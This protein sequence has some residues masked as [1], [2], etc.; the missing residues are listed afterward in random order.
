MAS[1]ASHTPSAG[2]VSFSRKKFNKFSLESTS[3]RSRAGAPSFTRMSV[4]ATIIHALKMAEDK[5]VVAFTV[6]RPIFPRASSVNSALTLAAARALL[7]TLVSKQGLPFLKVSQNGQLIE[8][9]L[10]V[11]ASGLFLSYSPTQRGVLSATVFLGHVHEARPASD[12]FSL[13]HTDLGGPETE[14]QCISLVMRHCAPWNVL[15]N[16]TGTMAAWQYTFRFLSRRALE[17]QRRHGA[18]VFLMRLWLDVAFGDH[19]QLRKGKGDHPDD[20][21]DRRDEAGA[22]VADGGAAKAVSRGELLS[23]P[24]EYVTETGDK[25]MFRKPGAVAVSGK[26]H[27]VSNSTDGPSQVP[28]GSLATASSP[29]E[30]RSRERDDATPNAPGEA[31]D[32]DAT[33]E[34]HPDAAAS[35]APAATTARAAISSGNTNYAQ[36][37]LT[38]THVSIRNVADALAEAGACRTET[39]LT[40]QAILPAV[41]TWFGSAAPGGD[42][43]VGRSLADDPPVA[44]PSFAA[45]VSGSLLSP[46]AFN[47]SSPSFTATA[48]PARSL[49]A[50]QNS[51]AYNTRISFAAFNELVGHCAWSG[52]CETIRPLFLRYASVQHEVFHML[53]SS[54]DNSLLWAAPGGGGG[55]GAFDVDAPCEVVAT[56]LIVRRGEGDVTN[57]SAFLP[58]TPSNALPPAALEAA[59]LSADGVGDPAETS[60]AMRVVTV[61]DWLRF[62]LEEQFE[63][64]P[65]LD[66]QKPSRQVASSSSTAG[67]VQDT[68]SAFFAQ[69]SNW[70]S[71]VTGGRR[72]CDCPTDVQTAAQLVAQMK[73]FV[74]PQIALEDIT[75]AQIWPVKGQICGGGGPLHR[76]HQPVD[77]SATANTAALDGCMRGGAGTASPGPSNNKAAASATG[78]SSASIAAFVSAFDNPLMSLASVNAANATSLGTPA[79]YPSQG[80]WAPSILARAV[81]P[82]SATA[83]PTTTTYSPAGSSR[84]LTAVAASIMGPPSSFSSP[85]PATA[86]PPLEHQP[87]LTLPLFVRALMDPTRNGWFK[88]HHSTTIHEDMKQPL[89]H[90]FVKSSHNTYL[91]GDQL[92]S[93]SSCEMYRYALL[94]GCR[95]LELD[96][97][98]GDDGDPII[99]HGHTRTTK[100][101]F[102]DVIKTIDSF[103]FTTSPF[104]VILSLEVHCSDE[105]QQVMALI[106]QTHFREKML[107]FSDDEFQQAMERHQAHINRSMLLEEKRRL[108]ASAPGGGRGG[109]LGGGHASSRHLMSLAASVE[110]L[111]GED[112]EYFS[113]ASASGVHPLS[114]E[115]LKFKILVKGKRS[116][117]KKAT[118]GEKGGGGWGAATGAAH[119]AGAGG[120]EDDDDSSSSDE[121]EGGGGKKSKKKKEKPTSTLTE[122]ANS[123]PPHRGGVLPPTTRQNEPADASSPHREDSNGGDRGVDPDDDLEGTPP[124]PGAPDAPSPL[125]LTPQPPQQPQPSSEVLQTAQQLAQLLRGFARGRQ[126]RDV[127]AVAAK[128]CKDLGTLW[129]GANPIHCCSLGERRIQRMTTNYLTIQQLLFVTRHMFIRVYPAGSRIAS[130]N[131]DPLWSWAHGAQLVALNYQTM[132][133]PMRLNT[134]MFLANGRSGYV[135]KPLIMRKPTLTPAMPGPAAIAASGKDENAAKHKKDHH[136]SAPDTVAHHPPRPGGLGS[137]QLHSAGQKCRAVSFMPSIS[138]SAMKIFI[139][140]VKVICGIALPQAPSLSRDRAKKNGKLE[141]A[142][143]EKMSVTTES[144]ATSTAGAE[145]GGA[146]DG[147]R[148]DDA[149]VATN[150][151]TFLV[152]RPF[153]QIAVSGMA[154]DNTTDVELMQDGSKGKVK[155]TPSIGESSSG[156]DAA[157]SSSPSAFRHHPPHASEW[158]NASR[159]AARAAIIAQHGFYSQYAT[160]AQYSRNRLQ[161]EAELQLRQMQRSGAGGVAGGGGGT[162]RAPP[163]VAP[164]PDDLPTPPDVPPSH[165]NRAFVTR[166]ANGSF[167]PVWL[168]EGSFLI[169]HLE[170]AVLTVRVY[171]HTGA[172]NSG[173]SQLVGESIIRLPSLRLGYR[174]VPL[175]TLNGQLLDDSAILCHFSLFEVNAVGGGGVPA[176]GAP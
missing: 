172:S 55:R 117:P 6:D 24:G 92:Q 161:Y 49:L 54:T 135:L 35:A 170:M 82:S 67:N 107:L 53:P 108:A 73:P 131:Y 19:R 106:M 66:N 148:G 56:P 90:Y 176:A 51:E 126:L 59:K 28:A 153:V 4:N 30:A 13:R 162:G 96:C 100:I 89:S 25:F 14:G 27:A 10:H 52:L 15:F 34:N 168:D 109:L 114:P 167:S 97:W 1:I 81:G 37:T 68:S 42:S 98:D 9:T 95:C 103:A 143:R 76:N 60:K 164:R 140:R 174:A 150:Q 33:P 3:T 171:D 142:E 69:V 22:T 158:A 173:A 105:Q 8:K 12:A 129:E 156:T 57:F 5:E 46:N 154:T 18:R 17:V 50:L 26:S 93:E 110:N 23:Q 38:H 87:V 151:A 39:L 160:L 78:V 64:V 127:I 118:V 169:S 20:D 43:G 133:Y 40:L 61:E 175:R 102:E 83:A 77:E 85:P 99:Y 152:P 32:T 121:G 63:R 163:P 141:K 72:L 65:S 124:D 104:P 147:G 159:E 128:H 155:P 41:C 11:D 101:L 139:L 130:S 36:H 58:A 134:A 31:P 115:A 48:L 112:I 144:T 29:E 157:S 165:G 166:C 84:W 138:S 75:A 125:A 116:A 119:K 45:S 137:S 80:P 79:K 132:D 149:I 86:P 16:G 111:L 62:Q 146:A 71:A 2:C 88:P 136:G 94:Q 7:E 113:H 74:T 91:T 123:D 122:A 21:P 47:V 70:F 44:S 145:G 120:G